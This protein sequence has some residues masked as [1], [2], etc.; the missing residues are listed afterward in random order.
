[1]LF[2]KKITIATTLFITL[3]A[4]AHNTNHS[5][6]APSV[7]VMQSVDL[8]NQYATFSSSYN[9]YQVSEQDK[10]LAENL[11]DDL[12]IDVYFGTWCHDSQREVP[13]LLKSF[14]NKAKQ[15]IN[16]IAVDYKKT[17]PSGMAK[18]KGI[19]FTPTF[20]ISRKGVELGRIIERP[21]QSLIA[22][23]QAML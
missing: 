17:E 8:L 19:S 16:L 20:I 10:Q 12:V 9:Q 4:C 22:D 6:N 15:T 14:G 1:M 23:I 11:P 13:R 2:F 18:E 5:D 7:G 3:S 21:Q